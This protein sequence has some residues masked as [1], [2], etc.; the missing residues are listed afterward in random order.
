MNRWNLSKADECLM[1][2]AA[3]PRRSI[4]RE[5]A[6]IL[7]ALYLMDQAARIVG[8][9]GT[10]VLQMALLRRVAARLTEAS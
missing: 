3:E 4:D 2:F 10:P 8:G 1:S 5:G 9:G 7:E 6:C